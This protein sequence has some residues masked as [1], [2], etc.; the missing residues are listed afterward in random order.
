MAAPHS[1]T[2]LPSHSAHAE[3]ERAVAEQRIDAAQDSDADGRADHAGDIDQRGRGAGA[4]GRN[5][6]D[7]DREQGTGRHT[8]AN[9]A[10]E[11]SEIPILKAFCL[12]A[13]S[14]RFSLFAISEAGV[15]RRAIVFRVRT[16]SVVQVRRTFNLLA[17]GCLPAAIGCVATIIRN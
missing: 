12:V 6:A 10:L 5:S 17:I 3:A 11:S 16:C 1:C 14:V 8:H 2:A 13:P 9:Q 4:R 7:G 15:L